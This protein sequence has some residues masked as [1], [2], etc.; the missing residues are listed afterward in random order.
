MHNNLKHQFLRK[1]FQETHKP[2]T[3]LFSIPLIGAI[4][5]NRPP[6]SQ[7]VFK[8]QGGLFL[9]LA[10]ESGFDIINL[11]KLSLDLTHLAKDITFNYLAE[12][13]L[14]LALETRV[15]ALKSAIAAIMSRN[16]SHNIGSHILSYLKSYIKGIPSTINDKF[17]LELQ[18]ISEDTI[19]N[20]IYELKIS[21]KYNDL[22]RI[23][24]VELEDY[25]EAPFSFRF[26]KI[27]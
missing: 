21:K 4:S 7:A 3:F 9:F 16:L 26:R 8:G 10:I 18:N 27:H 12:V 1:Y 11:K 5:N 24:M 19:D 17:L 6:K 13:G 2:K 14:N 22:I 20:K 23:S 25:M 15:H